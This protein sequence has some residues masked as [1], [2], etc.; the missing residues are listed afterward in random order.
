MK[1]SSSHI[2]YVDILILKILAAKGKIEYLPREEK[3]EMYRFSGGYYDFKDDGSLN[4]SHYYIAD[5]MGNNRMVVN[6]R[7]RAVEQVNHYYA[8]G[9]RSNK[10]GC[11]GSRFFW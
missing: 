4:D 7:T 9:P 2:D 8:Y 1:S 5:Y 3:P 6:G 10:E 11:T